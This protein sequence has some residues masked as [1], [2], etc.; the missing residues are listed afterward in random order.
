MFEQLVIAE[1]S[2]IK[3]LAVQQWGSR[4]K[5]AMDCLLYAIESVINRHI[6]DEENK[7]IDEI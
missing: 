3:H 7:R 6:H 5:S 2:E 4:N 1:G